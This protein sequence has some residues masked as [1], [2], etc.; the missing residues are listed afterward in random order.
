MSALLCVLAV[1]LA[2]APPALVPGAEAAWQ[3]AGSTELMIDFA[4]NDSVALYFDD[5]GVDAKGQR[6]SPSV[7]QVVASSGAPV[8]QID[9]SRCSSLA[10]LGVTADLGALLCLASNREEGPMV[11]H[12]QELSELS[13]FD[14]ASGKRRW[15]Y[16]FPDALAFFQ[17]DGPACFVQT[18]PGLVAL[19]AS[20]GRTLWRTR[21]AGDAI[22]GGDSLAY[23]GLALSDKAVFTVTSDDYG[24]VRLVC[25]ARATG[26]RLWSV[27]LEG[28]PSATQLNLASGLV[29]VSFDASGCP[30]GTKGCTTRALQVR[31]FDQ[32]RGA[33]RWSRAFEAGEVA[34]ADRD[35]V[36]VSA[37]GVLRGLEATSGEERFQ[38]AA[39]VDAAPVDLNLFSH[40]L[41]TATHAVGWTF[42]APSAQT[43][44]VWL[45]R[46]TG[47][48]LA[49][50]SPPLDPKGEGL[51]PRTLGASR[52]LIFVSAHG[53]LFA[54]R[55]A[56]L[57]P[58]PP[59]ISPR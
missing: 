10:Q 36:L 29:L 53:T 6:T 22:A 52:Q 37:G 51:G 1:A 17:C 33:A 2:S 7:R 27:V 20:S 11:R 39:S 54:L 34:A 23:E 50:W 46:K 42:D 19:D 3:A 14:L 16:R 58:P 5:Q 56:Q 12:A 13:A 9:L 21:G 4:A 43:L 26:R 44:L 28:E 40:W 41:L 32:G 30:K 57:L 47:D 45:D 48:R 38:A 35:L 15:G 8:R 59:P 55:P 18:M 25:L 31:A 24:K 49:S